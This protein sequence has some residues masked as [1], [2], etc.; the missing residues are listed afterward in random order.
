VSAT[1][2]ELGQ[3]KYANWPDCHILTNG[4]RRVAEGVKNYRN[5]LLPARPDIHVPALIAKLKAGEVLAPIIAV[6]GADDVVLVEG[7]MRAM[8]Y[9]Q[10]GAPA[11]VDMILGTSPNIRQWPLY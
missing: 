11:A 8:A 3:F 4:T 2:A 5:V 6:N 10:V 9:A 7:H 1:P